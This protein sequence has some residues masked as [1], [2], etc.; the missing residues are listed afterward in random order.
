MATEASSCLVHDGAF[1]A[2]EPAA[3]EERTVVASGEKAGLLTFAAPGDAKARIALSWAL[4]RSNLAE[5]ADEQ[6][7]AAAALDASLEAQRLGGPAQRLERVLP[8][9]AALV[10]DAARAQ[11]ARGEARRGN[12]TR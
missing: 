11:D 3:L 9:E 2:L 10:I 4:R 5:E 6:W 12:G 7:R 1:V 8:S